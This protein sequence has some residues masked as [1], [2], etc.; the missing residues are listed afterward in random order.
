MST[1]FLWETERKE[2]GINGKK[3]MKRGE[4]GALKVRKEKNWAAG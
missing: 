2:G 3:G 4:T 1:G